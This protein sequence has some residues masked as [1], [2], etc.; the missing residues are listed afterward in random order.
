ML[1]NFFQINILCES[2]KLGRSL[3]ESE[4]DNY[5]SIEK[6][7]YEIDVLEDVDDVKLDFGIDIVEDFKFEKEEFEKKLFSILLLMEELQ[8]DFQKKMEQF[9]VEKKVLEVELLFKI[10]EVE[11]LVFQFNLRDC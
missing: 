2:C 5:Q 8:N 6:F 10:F 3:E 9:E 11:D 7:V 1:E 4:G